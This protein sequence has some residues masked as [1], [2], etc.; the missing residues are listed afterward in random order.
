MLLQL[1]VPPA[2]VLISASEYESWKE[3]IDILS[4]PQLLKSIQAG[5]KDVQ[6]GRVYDWDE[7]KKE[8][9]LKIPYVLRALEKT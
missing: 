7:V 1:M 6:K 8:L 2:A 4:D 3:T 5:E 9:K